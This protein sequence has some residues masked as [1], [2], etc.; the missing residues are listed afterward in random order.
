MD[1]EVVQNRRKSLLGL[2]DCCDDGGDSI[3][4]QRVNGIRATACGLGLH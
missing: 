1:A 2:R 4:G 3:A